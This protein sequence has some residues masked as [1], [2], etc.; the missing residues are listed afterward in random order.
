MRR[1]TTLML[2]VL[3]A[4][5]GFD[6]AADQGPPGGDGANDFD[7]VV[8]V[9]VARQDSSLRPPVGEGDAD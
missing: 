6:I 3:G 7:D 4:W 2:A 5:G 8:L 1:S 9:H